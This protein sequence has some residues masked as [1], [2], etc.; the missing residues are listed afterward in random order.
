MQDTG[1]EIAAEL[2]GPE[3]MAGN[4]RRL[5]ALRE[6]GAER[7]VRGKPGRAERRE[8]RRQREAEAEPFL[9]RERTTGA[10]HCRRTRGSSQA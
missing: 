3:H 10:V 5:E 8:Q 7:I 1:E 6:I 9:Q 4:T 2:V